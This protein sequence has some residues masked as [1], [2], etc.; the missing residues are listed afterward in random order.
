MDL[1]TAFFH[2][3][4]TDL[5]RI[6]HRDGPDPMVAQHDYVELQTFARTQI[7]PLDA[8]FITRL[9]T[10]LGVSLLPNC[11]ALSMS[12]LF[13]SYLAQETIVNEARARA[14]DRDMSEDRLPGELV[15]TPSSYPLEAIANCCGDEAYAGLLKIRG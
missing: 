2:A 7:G 15:R 9:I 8:E 12:A 5:P 4:Y 3:R 11:R 14:N 10:D 13:R 1:V 6:V